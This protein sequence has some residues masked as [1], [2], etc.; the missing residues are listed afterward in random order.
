MRGY[1]A[2]LGGGKDVRLI[3]RDYSDLDMHWVLSTRGS[4]GGDLTVG[5]VNVEGGTVLFPLLARARHLI[6]LVGMVSG[7]VV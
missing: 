6:F 3:V 2:S 1:M 5:H 4:L 7:I